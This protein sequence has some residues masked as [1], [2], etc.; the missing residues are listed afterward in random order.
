MEKQILSED[1]KLEN[2]ES[3]ILTNIISRKDILNDDEELKEDLNVLEFQLSKINVISELEH[4]RGSLGWICKKDIE[5]IMTY[6]NPPPLINCILCAAV[7][8][9]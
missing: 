1:L 5:E 7:M 2:S 3:F 4:A 8:L 6:S 9:L